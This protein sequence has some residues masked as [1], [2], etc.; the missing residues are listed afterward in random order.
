[1]TKKYMSLERLQEYD[2]LIKQEIADSVSGKANA[3]H[4]HAISSVTN[5][6]TTLDNKAAKSHTHT[7][8][9]ISDLTANVTEI[10]YLDGVSS[11]IQ[12]QLDGKAAASHGN[13]VP[14]VQTANNAK[15]LRNDN[16]WQTVTPANIGAATSGHTHNNINMQNMSNKDL[17]TL[18]TQG[19][20]YG[21]TG[22][23]NAP[24]QTIGVMEVL[25]YSQDW[26]VQRFT[27][28]GATPV[29]YERH[30]HTGTTWGSWFTNINSGNISSQSVNYATSA[31]S[32]TKATTAT[33]VA[34]GG[35]TS[36]PS[37]YDAKAIKGITRSGT[38]FT[39]TCMDG[40]T[41]TFTQQ[42]NNTTYSVVST[43]ANGLMSATDK[44]KLNAMELATLA[45]VQTYLGI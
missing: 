11:N 8:A 28:I 17:N 42:D 34:W 5:L 36:K 39:Y 43:T 4:S 10:N 26:I 6:Q 32:A 13:H 15:F 16:T 37:Y 40:T 38:T 2:V 22:M 44:V 14:A 21:Y 19:W 18:K 33:N 1:M 12:S 41:G 30:Y 35:V 9:N 20:Y 45:E 27:V 7:V 29:T 24:V 25:V 23:T 31:G 3:S